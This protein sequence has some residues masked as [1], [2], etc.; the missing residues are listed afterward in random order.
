[1]PYL[2]AVESLTWWN[3]HPVLVPRHV[4]V[5]VQRGQAGHKILCKEASGQ[6]GCPGSWSG[7]LEMNV[8]CVSA[9]QPL[10]SPGHCVSCG[11]RLKGSSHF[12][13]VHM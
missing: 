3:P 8:F 11:P 10:S 9:S 5:T 6:A 7:A 4:P 2:I 13:D 1:M 12:N